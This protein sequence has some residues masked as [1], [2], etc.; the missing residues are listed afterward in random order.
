MSFWDRILGRDDDAGGQQNTQRPGSSRVTRR[1]E[2]EIAVERYRYLLRTAP[3]ETIEQVHVEAFTKLTSEQRALLFEQLKQNAAEG[4]RPA[5]DQPASLARSA[6][7]SEMRQP[8]TLERS[9]GGGRRDGGIGMGGMIA[10]S[11]LGTIAGVVVGSALAQ[12]FLPD[13]FGG[14]D[15]AAAEGG[16]AAGA[17][18][19]GGDV[20]GGDVGGG[21]FGGGDFGF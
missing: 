14:V 10:G 12:A 21:D 4:D 13:S 15:A 16:E 20:G 1:S 6:T 5:D 2:D 8:G 19:A 7:R 11:M 3:P 18:D 17:E 9:F